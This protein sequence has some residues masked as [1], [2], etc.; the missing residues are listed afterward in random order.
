MTASRI[1]ADM[2][3]PRRSK[4]ASGYRRHLGVD[5]QGRVL[6]WTAM[7]MG[8]DIGEEVVGEGRADDVV[9]GRFE[10]EDR[11]PGG[12]DPVLE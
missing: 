5:H 1:S 6:L 7:P 12:V 4:V 9:G 10:G 8:A 11:Q 2:M 3:T